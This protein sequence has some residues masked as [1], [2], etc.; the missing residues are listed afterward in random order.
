MFK[1]KSYL[2]KSTTELPNI[3]RFRMSGNNI[4]DQ[5][6]LADSFVLFYIF[7]RSVF[8]ASQGSVVALLLMP[9]TPD[10]EV[11]D[12]SP[13][14]IKLCCVLEQGTFTP[15][16][17]L[18]IPRKRW[19]RPNMTDI[20]NQSTNQPILSCHWIKSAYNY[21]MFYKYPDFA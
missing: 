13:T 7:T 17:V 11:G 19:L 4:A 15:Q 5:K 16:K 1:L 2:K 20:K 9:R 18:V 3:P 8:L 12:S 14:R 6:H 21:N 10:P